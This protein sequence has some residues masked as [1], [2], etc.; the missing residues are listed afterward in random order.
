ML[1]YDDKVNNIKINNNN[2]IYYDMIC[3]NFDKINQ[4]SL[5]DKN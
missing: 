1:E 3:V 2:I 5:F 4:N